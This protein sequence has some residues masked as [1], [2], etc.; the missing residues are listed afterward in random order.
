VAQLPG[1]E[2]VRASVTV[3]A[4]DIVRLDRP[5]PPVQAALVVQVRAGGADAARLEA[6][7]SSALPPGA[8]LHVE[9]SEAAPAAPER[10]VPA[11]AATRVGPFH[12][13]GR[14]AGWLRVTLGLLLVS[15]ALLAGLVL[16]KRARR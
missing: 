10:A 16:A 3:P 8:L 7:A 2:R 9:R 15:N 12:V 14:S 4:A 6:L 11:A 1:V 13:E 5:L